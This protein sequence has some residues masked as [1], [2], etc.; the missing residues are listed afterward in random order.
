MVTTNFLCKPNEYAVDALRIVMI[1][2]NFAR[3]P[4]DLG[5]IGISAAVFVLL[6]TIA[7]RKVQR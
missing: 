3:L 5:G 1:T 4:I 7:F 6:A 2:G